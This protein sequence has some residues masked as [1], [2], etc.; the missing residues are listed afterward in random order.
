MTKFDYE[1]LPKKRMGSGCLLFNDNGNVLLVKPSYR[2]GWERPGG[3]VERN[4]SP[5]QCCQR[6]VKEELGFDK[7]IERLLLVDY[8]GSVPERTES[9]MFVFYVGVL[10]SVEIDQ[11]QLQPE[12]LLPIDFLPKTHPRKK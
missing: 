11:M 12:E 3:V 2:P 9:L 4:E 5:K 1:S 8:N 7:L 6:E 10:P